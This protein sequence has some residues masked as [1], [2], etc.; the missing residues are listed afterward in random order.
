MPPYHFDHLVHN[1]WNI[2]GRMRRFVLI[3]RSI[4]LVASIILVNQDGSSPSSC[5]QACPPYLRL[6]SSETESSIKYF[7]LKGALVMVFWHRSRKVTKT[8]S[9]HIWSY[10]RLLLY[11]TNIVNVYLILFWL[12]SVFYTCNW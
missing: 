5:C 1:Y 8:I 4:S 7:I 10:F 2:F 6:L 11:L 3:G 12:E 9:L